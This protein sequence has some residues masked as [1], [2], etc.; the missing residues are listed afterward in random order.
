V[1]SQ[2]AQHAMPGIEMKSNFCKGG[3]YPVFPFLSD[4]IIVVKTN[5]N[6]IKGIWSRMS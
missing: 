2:N 4:V 1:Y 5:C 3:K 6:L